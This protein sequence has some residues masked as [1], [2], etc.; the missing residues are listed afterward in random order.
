MT[1]TSHPG[2]ALGANFFAAP[3]PVGRVPTS[4]SGDG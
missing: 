1:T 3:L 2:A 4:G